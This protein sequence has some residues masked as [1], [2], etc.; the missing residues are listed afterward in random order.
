MLKYLLTKVFREQSTSLLKKLL[1]SD[2]Y[3]AFSPLDINLDA[4]MLIH[5]REEVSYVFNFD[6]SHDCSLPLLKII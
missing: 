3:F 4:L 1:F 2:S 6:F 5:F